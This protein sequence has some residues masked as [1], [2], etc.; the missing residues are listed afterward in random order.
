MSRGGGVQVAVVLHT[1]REMIRGAGDHGA[2]RRM[3]GKGA[4]R[5]EIEVAVAVAPLVILAP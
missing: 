1:V 3:G 5:M 2:P 4:A